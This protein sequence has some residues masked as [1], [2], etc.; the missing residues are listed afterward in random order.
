VITVL[1]AFIFFE[2]LPRVQQKRDDLTADAVL[3]SL[4]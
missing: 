1:F 2:A 4:L 3:T